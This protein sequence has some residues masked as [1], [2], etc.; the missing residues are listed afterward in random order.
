VFA[1]QLAVVVDD[2]G[3]GITHVVRG[4]DLLAS[5]PW[6][7]SLQR[8]LGFVS[9]AYAHLPLLVEPDGSKLA[10]SRRSVPLNSARA[11]ALL[12]TCLQLLRQAPP[13]GL[14]FETPET[15]LR[16]GIPHWN[17]QAFHGIREL[18]APVP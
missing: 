5:T 10:K 1:Y 15:I 7:L 2:A 9:P 8:A 6:Q 18:A 3:Q 13:L 14:E 12:F 11:G 17:P 16:W 4:A